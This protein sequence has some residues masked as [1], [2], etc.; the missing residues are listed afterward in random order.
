MW[1]IDA[2]GELAKMN[3]KD[4]VGAVYFIETWDVM[5]K[6]EGALTAAFWQKE[7]DNDSGEV[8]IFEKMVPRRVA[9]CVTDLFAAWMANGGIPGGRRELQKYK[10]VQCDS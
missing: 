4:G 5:L 1:I 3:G 2:G 7:K 10:A 6:A 8:T 9:G